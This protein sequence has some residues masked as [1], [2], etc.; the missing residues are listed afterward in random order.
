[1]VQMIEDLDGDWRRLDQ[2]IE[3][4]SDEINDNSLASRAA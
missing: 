1:M 2:R 4:L 3:G